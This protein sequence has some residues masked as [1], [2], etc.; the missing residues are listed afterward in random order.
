[1]DGHWY[2]FWFADRGDVGMPIKA[3]ARIVT[4]N[5]RTGRVSITDPAGDPNPFAKARQQ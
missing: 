5:G 3:E 1:M 4:L 2:H